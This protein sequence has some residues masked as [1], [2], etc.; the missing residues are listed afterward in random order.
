MYF[1]PVSCKAAFPKL[2]TKMPQKVFQIIMPMAEYKRNFLADKCNTP[3][4]VA[5][6]EARFGSQ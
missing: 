4:A 5:V 2:K 6:I 3:A 1:N